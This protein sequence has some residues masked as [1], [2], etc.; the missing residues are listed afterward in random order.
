[1]CEYLSDLLNQEVG[2]YD[3]NGELSNN[4]IVLFENTRFF[5]VDNKKEIN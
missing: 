1:M 3:Y 2:F 4:K 5:D